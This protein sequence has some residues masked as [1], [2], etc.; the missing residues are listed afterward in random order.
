MLKGRTLLIVSLCLSWAFFSGSLADAA[1][2][3]E[4]ILKGLAAR[5]KGLE[6]LTASYKRT[7]STNLAADIFEAPEEPKVSGQL[8]WRKPANM[9]LDQKTPSIELLV[10]DGQT[11]WWYLPKDKLVHVYRRLNLAGEMA[12]L[13]AFLT[14]LDELKKSFRIKEFPVHPLRPGQQ[15][16]IL[17]PKAKETSFGQIIAWSDQEF[18]LTGFDLLMA[19]GE[20]T[21]FYLSDLKE[22]P[23]DPAEF[24]FK[25]PK[26]VRTIEETPR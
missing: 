18:K 20:T 10:T 21:H 16:L 23:L 12:P 22:K 8:A 15:G 24:A 11:V 5:Y 19:T 17:V 9:R 26:G 1:L 4:E 6:G 3:G 25:A 2:S 13:L 14:N 7:T